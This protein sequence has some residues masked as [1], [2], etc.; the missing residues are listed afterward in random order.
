MKAIQASPV[1]FEF[2]LMMFR[3]L[4]EAYRARFAVKLA[5][6]DVDGK[7]LSSY[8]WWRGGDSVDRQKV[9]AFTVWQA[10]RLGEPTVSYGSGDRLYWACPVMCNAKTFGA[11]VGA[12]EV[13]ELFPDGG[14][15]PTVDMRGACRV[16]REMLEAENLTNA[17]FLSARRYEAMREQEKAQAI[18]SLKLE[19]SVGIR[20][21]YLREEPELVSAIRRGDRCGARE[22]LDRILLVMMA[23]SQNRFDLI[24]SYF[25]E[26]VTSVCRTAVE[27]GGDP[28]EILGESFHR[29]AELSSIT[30]LESLAPWMHEMLERLMDTLADHRESAGHIVISDAMSYMQA[31]L[32]QDIG[33]DDVADAMCL[34]PSHF[35]RL[36]KRHVGMG[37]REMLTKMRMD[38]GAELLVSTDLAVSAVA[39][40]T[41]YED[42]SY[43]TKVFQKQHAQTPRAYRQNAKAG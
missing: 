7:R 4:A 32:A 34:S 11:M 23:K 42:P 30:T 21:L 26:L 14:N 35:S 5:V 19:G 9:L 1:N 18:H 43:F 20:R 8:G 27:A 31:H 37:F 6:V 40:A 13:D 33:R 38:R 41:G 39:L 22:T 12:I 16:L 10:L 3:R 36:F 29:I 15:V 28:N 25:M 24:K 17:A 2:D